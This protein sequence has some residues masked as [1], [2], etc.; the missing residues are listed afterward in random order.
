MSHIFRQLPL[1]NVGRL[2]I[3]VHDLQTMQVLDTLKELPDNGHAL[4]VRGHV[5]D[6]IVQGQPI[7]AELHADLCTDTSN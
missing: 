7:V 4:G 1:K 2:K 5:L 6:P 3:P